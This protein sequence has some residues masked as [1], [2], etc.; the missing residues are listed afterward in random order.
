MATLLYLV[1]RMPYPPDKGD[2]VRSYH[3]LKH[4]TARHRVFLGT[5]IDD[6]DDERHV[7]TVAAMTAGLHVARLRPRWARPASLAGLLSGEA[8]TLRY[9]ADAGLQRWVDQTCSRQR[10]DA[11]LVFSST[12]AQFVR[13]L[14][15]VPMLVDFVDVDSAKWDQYASMHRWPM[16]WVYRR[17]GA[18]LLAHERAV[19][20]R[21]DHSFFVTENET[22]LFRRLAPE[23][24]AMVE[25]LS[26]GVDGEYFSVDPMRTS[27]FV[28]G[29]RTEGAD[30]HLPL[31]F[32][33]AMDY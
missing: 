7:A 14:R 23:C 3:L 10:I 28:P 5:F 6:P 27:P 31:V 1:H 33:G 2:K 26:N 12:M 18:L 8:L 32:T 19:A 24:T 30:A 25:S 21:A 11:V 17:E 16:S 20:A 15:N 22:A 9:Y 13:K 29:Y 4:L